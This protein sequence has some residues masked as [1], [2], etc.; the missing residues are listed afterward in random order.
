MGQAFQSSA[1]EE[2]LKAAQKRKHL[3]FTVVF[4]IVIVLLGLKSFQGLVDFYVNDVTDY[5]EWTADLGNRFETDEASS[6]FG[7]LQFINFNGAVRNVLG[8]REMNEVTKLK[9]GHL[10]RPHYPAGEDMLK[11]YSDNVIALD[12]YLKEKG[13]P[14]IY[15]TPPYTVS[16]YDPELPTGVHDYANENLDRFLDPLEQAGVDVMDLRKLMKDDGIDHYDM[17]YKTDHH[18]TTEAA[19]YA[20]GK[21]EDRLVEKL[22]CEVDERVSDIA[23]YDVITY[24]K[25]HLGSYGQRTGVYYAGID[26]FKLF[27]PRFSTT[28]Q[29]LS[30]LEQGSMPQLLYD[31]EPLQ[32]RDMKSKYTYDHVFDDTLDNYR[33]LD[34]PNDRKIMI[35]TDSFGKA[36]TPYLVMGFQEVRYV[37]DDEMEQFTKESIDQYAPD[38]VIILYHADCLSDHNDKLNFIDFKN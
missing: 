30:D 13:I 6:F 9:N 15:V 11:T 28:I 33:N 18:W 7:K 14:L 38:A 3:S 20:Y 37:A 27:V 36:L 12:H 31:M 19:F 24:E 4:M 29:R 2:S 22:H 10:L 23:S 21:L 26:D 34:C 16:K 8:Q 17:M 25:W 1:S 35:L 32:N 5:N